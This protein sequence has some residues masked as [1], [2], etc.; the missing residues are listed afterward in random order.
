MQSSTL[1]SIGYRIVLI[2]GFDLVWLSAVVGRQDYLWLTAILVALVYAVNFKMVWSR[3]A[4]I[5]YLITFGLL[6]EW[7]VVEL[8]VLQFS[9]TSGLPSWLVLL[10]LGFGALAFTAMDWLA[11]R[12]TLAWLLGIVFGPLTYVAGIRFGAAELT[13]TYPLLVVAYGFKWGVIM[14]FLAFLSSRARFKYE[15]A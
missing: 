15:M 2:L 3:R 13:S 5:L 11:G 14:H 12:Y 8:G 7:L 10:W 6:C 9:G 1:W 4:E